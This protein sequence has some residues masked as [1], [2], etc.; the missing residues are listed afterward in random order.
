VDDEFAKLGEGKKRYRDA[1]SETVLKIHDAIRDTDAR[2]SLLS[3]QIGTDNTDAS[4]QG[5]D[6]IWNSIRRMYETMQSIQLEIEKVTVLSTNAEE[7]QNT[8]LSKMDTLAQNFL[9][10]NKFTQE[11]LSKIAQ[12]V[13]AIESKRNP[14]TGV[15]GSLE[16]RRLLDRIGIV[17][18]IIKRHTKDISKGD[19]T[20]ALAT[21]NGNSLPLTASI[22]TLLI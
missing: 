10:L 13:R 14:T 6:S 17:D 3:A 12:K 15:A 21:L 2:A 19:R 7:V 9:T 22:Q 4:S 18:D 5:T 1:I 11:N 8:V 20:I 16:Y